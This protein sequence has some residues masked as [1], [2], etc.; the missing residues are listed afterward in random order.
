[1]DAE[2]TAVAEALPDRAPRT[3]SG[4]ALYLTV[5]RGLKDDIVGGVYPV[6]SQLPTEAELCQRFSVSRHT[7]REALRLLR[8]E[9]LVASRQ[10]AG[11]VV[12][13][14][15][16]DDSFVLEAHSIDDLLAYADSMH[17]EVQ[18][19]TMELVEG[20]LAARLGIAGGEEWLVVR[21]FARADGM[22]LPVCWSEYYINRD[23]AA[24]GR[25]L[26][27]H[28]GPI[29]LLLE[30][31]FGLNIAEIDQEISVGAVPPALATGLKAE[32]GTTAI[33]VRRSFST[34]D[35][36]I[37]QVTLHTHPATRFRQSVKMRR[38]KT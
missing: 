15:P 7:V 30:D 4:N 28:T 11:T 33:E 14:P 37:A 18:S 2:S 29:F 13:P 1:M 8:E 23:Y 20:R 16:S 26:P 3:G 10:G 12:V 6:G 38:I 22:K 36:K 19:T 5:A 24:V 9:R 35:G 32:A 17:T 27:R 21:G 34:A 31:L 25:L